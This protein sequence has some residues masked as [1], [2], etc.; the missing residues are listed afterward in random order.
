MCGVVPWTAILTTLFPVTQG[1]IVTPQRR[2]LENS[3]SHIPDLV[4]E[5]IR[6]TTP[7]VIFRTV[8]ILKVEN[9]QHWTSGIPVLEHQ[10]NRQTDPAFAGTAF[11]KV[12]WIGTIC[13]HWRYGSKDDDGQGPVPLIN[14]HDIT[15]D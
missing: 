4:I 5:V 2:I 13:P 14:W 11:R 15:H 12:Y 3:E 10:I 7:P 1:Y 9:S 6:L 8:L